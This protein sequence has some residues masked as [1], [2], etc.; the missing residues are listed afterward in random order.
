MADEFVLYISAA[1][2]LAIERDLIART[3]TEIPVTLGWRIFQSP[4]RGG[5]LN[6]EALQNA[7][8]HLLLIGSDI[9]A[10][11]GFEWALARK[12]GRRTILFRKTGILVTPAG[13]RFIREINEV[14]TW[15][16][17]ED[18]ASLRV[19]ILK[20]IADHIIEHAIHFALRG[21]EYEGLINWR[22]KLAHEKPAPVQEE[23]G[24][25]GNSSVILSRERYIPKEGK[26]LQAKRIEQNNMRERVNER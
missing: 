25:A 10:P 3:V 20:L 21:D 18:S 11:I 1:Q 22:E 14:A 12:A 2:D 7:D 15:N 5:H 9:R 4:L 24:G 8:I 19:E 13:E 16:T 23:T 17:F 6:R 26:L